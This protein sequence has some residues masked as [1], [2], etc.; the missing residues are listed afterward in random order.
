MRRLTLDEILG[1][2]E[3]EELRNRPDVKTFEEL[4]EAVRL[5]PE[6]TAAEKREQA[7]SFVWGNLNIEGNVP[8]HLV[9]EA[10]DRRHPKEPK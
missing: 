7:I 10:Y 6:M 8:R 5:L 2:T 1:E 3:P 9:E 4:L